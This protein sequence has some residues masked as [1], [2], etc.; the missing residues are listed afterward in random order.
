M[1]SLGGI[2]GS[3]ASFVRTKRNEQAISVAELIQERQNENLIVVGDFN[4]FQFTDGYVDV[5][6]QLEG[7]SSLGAL[8]PV[9]PIVSPP[10]TNIS[11]AGTAEERYS[12]VFQGS[13]QMLDHCLVTEFD[14]LDIIDFAFARGNADAASAY[15]LNPSITTRAS[16]H[17][18]FVLYLRPEAPIVN[19]LEVVMRANQWQIPNPLASG[20]TIVLPEDWTIPRLH[21]YTL[22]GKLIYTWENMRGQLRLPELASGLYLLQYQQQTQMRQVKL[23]IH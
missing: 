3:N 18:G 7:S 20:S 23:V 8:F 15:F 19:D 5:L 6:S 16:D 12:F 9:Q 13:A 1:R 4:A 2:E 14:G 10:L 11:T 22:D 17:D 21:L